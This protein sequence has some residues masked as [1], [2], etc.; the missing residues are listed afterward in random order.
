VI[1]SLLLVAASAGCG[2]RQRPG[3]VEDSV[4]S[5]R[6]TVVCPPEVHA[7]LVRERDAFQALY[8]QASIEI[9][10]GTAREAVGALFAGRCE[11]AV[12]AR[13]LRPEERAAALQGG[14]EL[15]GFRFAR[16]ALVF[17]VNPANPVQNVSV[18][19]VRGIYQGTVKQWSELGGRGQAIH[20]V[21]QPMESDMTAAFDERV[22]TGE[23]I[24]ARVFTEASDSAVAARVASDPQAVGY[25]SMAA[26]GR[27]T[28]ALRVA[29][30]RGLE[31]ARP[32]VETVYAGTYPAIRSY[33]YYLRAK[34]GLL[35]GG[36][37]T[38]ITTDDGQKIVHE[39][40]LVP[41]AVPVRFV[42]RS[43]MIPS[44]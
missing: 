28:A 7:L 32:D 44:H 10:V 35:A 33:G 31:Y 6:M 26:A 1:V 18:P 22:M 15:E 3:V 2:V 39:A 20:P 9:K 38:Y 25:V 27:G 41:T 40:G 36:F 43:P 12:V 17:I 42:H 29:A 37:I 19:Q 13:D 4:T 8:P 30:L 24:G 21:V 23:R 16:D 34:G 11:A 14:M 5:G